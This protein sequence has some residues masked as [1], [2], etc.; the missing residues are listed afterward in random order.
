MAETYLLKA[1]AQCTGR[2]A[3]QVRGAAARCGDLGRAAE[4]ARAAQRTLCAPAPLSVRRLFGALRD[5][6]HMTG[7][8]PLLFS[9]P[10]VLQCHRRPSRRLR[11]AVADSM[12]GLVDVE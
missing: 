1:V 11:S 2:S 3:A 7:E 6:A 5:V 4:R 8:L 9:G 12:R 10:R